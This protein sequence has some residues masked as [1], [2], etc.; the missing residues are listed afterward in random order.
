M[1][2]VWDGSGNSEM[3]EEDLTNDVNTYIFVNGSK[4]G[5]NPGDSFQNLILETAKGAGLGKFRVVLNGN[6][7]SPGDAPDK[8]EEGS[9]MELLP[10]DV[11]GI[12]E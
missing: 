1:E 5:V 7:V 6:E 4:I 12:V 3:Y 10:Y 9:H 8:I 2:E 11:A